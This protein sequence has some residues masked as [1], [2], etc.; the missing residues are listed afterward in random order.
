V[1]ATAQDLKTTLETFL[2]QTGNPAIGSAAAAISA[3][4]VSTAPLGTSTG[5]FTFSFDP[6]LRTW[7]R[8]ATTFGPAFSER[9]LTTGRLKVSAGLNYI[10]SSYHSI[11]GYDLQNGDF[12]P[13]T[14][15]VGVS[16]I[17]ANSYSSVQMHW[18]SDTVVAFGH[19]GVTDDLDLGVA[20]PWTRVSIE[21]TE[22]LIS[23]SG[24]HLFDSTLPATSDS[25]IGDIAIFGK[26]RIVRQEEGGVAAAVEVH[27]PTGSLANMRGLDTTRTLV[28]G[29]WS[30][31]GR[32]SPHL[33]VGYE[34]WAASVPLARDNATREVTVSA[35]NQ[36][37]YAIGLEIQPQ[38][39]LTFVIDLVGRHLLNGGELGY[40]S[41]STSVASTGCPSP[42]CS[43]NALFVLSNGIHVV[44]LAPSVK[45]NLWGS[46]LVT[47]NVLVALSN[48]GLRSNVIPV[49]GLDW[50][51]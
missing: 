24:T 43:S 17:P 42:P 21:G 38:P 47:G 36:V 11:G 40:Q 41:V 48:N 31:G 35:K 15:I 13:L 16:G 30:K 37:K 23:P 18:S 10:H 19:V 25:G 14:N 32:V 46:V 33:N 45:W 4:E 51:F 20:V 1:P 27:A 22:A 29:I 39:R 8:S 49:F 5:G 9:S 3:L 12:R 28:T 2:S 44:S 7:R 6:S 50:A 34:F 26:Y